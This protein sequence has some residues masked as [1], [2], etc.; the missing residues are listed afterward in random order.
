[1]GGTLSRRAKKVKSW[2]YAFIKPVPPAD[3]WGYA[4]VIGG[5]LGVP[6]N[7]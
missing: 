5:T 3:M 1:L 7:C 2:G 4:Y 6:K